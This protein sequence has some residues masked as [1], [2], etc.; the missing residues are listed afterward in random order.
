MRNLKVNLLDARNQ[1]RL[2]T[3]LWVISVLRMAYPSGLNSKQGITNLSLGASPEMIRKMWGTGD[4]GS[5]LDAAITWAKFQDLDQATQYWIVHLWSPGLPLIEVPLIWISKIGIPFMFLMFLLTSIIWFFAIKLL[6]FDLK[7][8]VLR[9]FSIIIW[10]IWA[11]SW[12][13]N[14]IFRDGLFY[15]EGIGY[16]LLFLSISLT[17]KENKLLLAG[18]FAGF[19]VMVRHVTDTG[20]LIIISL[21]GIFFVIPKIRMLRNRV[22]SVK[23]NILGKDLSKYILGSLIVTSLWRFIVSPIRYQG[24]FYF[25]SS[26]GT[27]VP[28]SIWA[29]DGGYWDDYNINWA[30]H[31]NPN[32]CQKIAHTISDNASNVYLMYEAFKTVLMNPFRYLAERIPY[33]YRHWAGDN[34]PGD[35]NIARLLT[36]FMIISTLLSIV[37]L[38]KSTITREKIDSSG[39][40]VVCLIFGQVLNLAIIHFE[41]RYFLPLRMLSLIFILLYLESKFTFNLGK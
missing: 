37:L 13:G 29:P 35:F 36:Y 25:L 8:S 26:A 24:K 4:A 5:L 27:V 33:L 7:H 15:S 12:D 40:I 32:T 18:V 22:D 10:I 17:R 6:V 1:L 14:Y 20:L 21:A 9:M 23:F 41:S 39:L 31:L 11:N 16:G 3:L 38:M 19:S 28:K 34:F 2:F 30:C